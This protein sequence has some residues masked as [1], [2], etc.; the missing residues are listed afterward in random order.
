[1]ASV[2]ILKP[3]RGGG[4]GGGGVYNWEEIQITFWWIGYIK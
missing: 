2:N 3:E 1:M 4:G